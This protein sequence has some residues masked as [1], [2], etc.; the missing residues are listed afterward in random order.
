M[1]R[2]YSPFD[3][4]TTA[5]HMAPDKE[6]K[7]STDA[8]LSLF[9]SDVRQ[10]QRPH[11]RDQLAFTYVECENSNSHWQQRDPAANFQ[12]EADHYKEAACRNFQS[13]TLV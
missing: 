4:A 9:R 11:N 5:P 10:G 6:L 8:A 3:G 12:E 13:A 7:L 1:P 2:N